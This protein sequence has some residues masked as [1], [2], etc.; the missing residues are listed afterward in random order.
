MFPALVRPVAQGSAG[1]AIVIE[2]EAACFYHPQKRAVVPCA[3]CGRFLCGLCDLE[4]NGRHVCATCLETGRRKGSM[5]ELDT[6]RTCYDSLA[7]ILAVIGPLL[8]I[9]GMFPLA[10]AAII[11]AIYGWRKPGSIVRR[12]RYL[13]VVAILLALLEILIGVLMVISFNWT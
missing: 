9:W 8:C 4:L 7:M 2:G 12:S 11:V 3:I 13:F 10:P 6:R 5:E 1:E